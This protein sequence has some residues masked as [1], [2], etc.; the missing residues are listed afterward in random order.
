MAAP[1]PCATPTA[2]PLP[3]KTPPPTPQRTAPIWCSL[4]VN[5]QEVVERYLNEAVAANTVENRGCAIVM[6]VKTGAILA[7]ASKPDFDP[8]DPQDFSANLAY[9]TEQVQ[10]EPELYTIYKKTRTATTCGREWPEDRGC[11]SRLH[12][13]LPGYPVEEQDHHRAV[14]PRKRVQGHHR[15]HGCGQRQGDLLHHPELL[16]RVQRGKA[17]LPLRRQKGARGPESGRGPAQQLQHL[18]CPAGPARGFQPVL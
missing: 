4:D 6:N 1:S 5:I 18:L 15:R 14:L 9:L 3:M 2:T 13:H 17:D 7:M 11:G 8:N 10:A 16:R 12:R